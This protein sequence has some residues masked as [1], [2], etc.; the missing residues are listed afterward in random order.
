MRLREVL[1]YCLSIHHQVYLFM[2]FSLM[3]LVV[4]CHYVARGQHYFAYMYW[5]DDDANT[6]CKT[7]KE[8]WGK[9]HSVME[10]ELKEVCEQVLPVK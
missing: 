2:L 4:V 9:Q 6:M 10:D 1:G 7:L 8:E 3:G 5:N